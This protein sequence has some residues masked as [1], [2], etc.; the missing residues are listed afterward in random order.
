MNT[1]TATRRDGLSRLRIGRASVLHDC[2]DIHSDGVFL[3][4][5]SGRIMW[6]DK[7]AAEHGLR[8]EANLCLSGSDV[9]GLPRRMTVCGDLYIYNTPR[10]AG[11]PEGLRVV[12]NLVISSAPIAAWPRDLWVG[13]N[14]HLCN[15][16]LTAPPDADSFDGRFYSGDHGT[17]RAA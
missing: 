14:I 13:G 5:G 4:A 12:G 15:T 17:G 2:P 1:P 7:F 6:L 9:T 8:V 16:S 3:A 10:L 11:L